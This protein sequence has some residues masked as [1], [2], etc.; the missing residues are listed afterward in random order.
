MIWESTRSALAAAKARGVKLG[1]NGIKLAAENHRN[2]VIYASTIAERF[3]AAR[4]VKHN[5]LQT[6][7]TGFFFGERPKLDRRKTAQ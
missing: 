2:A 1:L 3:S 5:K 7:T 4:A 6:G